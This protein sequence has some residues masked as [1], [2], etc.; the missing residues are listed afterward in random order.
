MLSFV[1]FYVTR[2]LSA[3]AIKS[4]LIPHQWDE[5]HLVAQDQHYNLAL[6]ICGSINCLGYFKLKKIFFSVS[7]SM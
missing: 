2:K 1:D 6:P 7:T 3:L 5:E 4:F